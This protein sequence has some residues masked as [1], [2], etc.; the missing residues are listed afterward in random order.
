[1]TLGQKLRQARLARGLTQAQAAGGRI[2]RN[3][4]SQIENDQASPSVRTLEYLAAALGVSAGWLLSDDQQD[5]E[6]GRLTRARAMLRGGEYDACLRLL[7]PAEASAGDEEL[8]ILSIAAQHLCEQALAEER[9]DDALRLARQALD[10]NR[11]SLYELPTLQVKASGVAARCCCI[12]R[13]GADEEMDAYKELYQRLQTAVDYHLLMA[14]YAL[15]REHIQAAEREIWSIADLPDES[16][17]EYLVLR[18]RIALRKEQLE[19]AIL[20]LRQAEELP[21]SPKLLRRELYK[22]LEQCY[23]ERE[24]YKQAY[25]YAAK[26]L[27]L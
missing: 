14:R 27:D 10:W 23:R 7:A 24:D 6:P 26:Q 9:A 11:R 4:L 17:A 22:C 19:N 8:L 16:R 1:M 5:S 13:S 2:T 18:G 15:D 20:Y 3:M 25:E 21:G 12:R